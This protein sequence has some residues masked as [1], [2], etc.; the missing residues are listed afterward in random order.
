MTSDELFDA[1]ILVVD[2]HPEN[3]MLLE[4]ML[5]DEGYHQITCVTDARQVLAMLTPA[6]DIILLDVRMPYLSGLDVLMLIRQTLGN[7]APPVVILTADNDNDTKNK[8]L[9]LGAID[10]LTK[11][12]DQQEVIQRIY[13]LL[14]VHLRSQQHREQA[15][16]LQELVDSQTAELRK[17]SLTDTLT[18]LPNR[19]ALLEESRLRLARN[20]PLAVLML[21]I[22]GLSNI[23][24]IQGYLATEALL[25]YLSEM[26]RQCAATRECF[27]GIWE[28]HQLVILSPDLDEEA[29]K[30]RAE[31]L[32]RLT[33]GEHTTDERL[34]NID[35]R[36]GCCRASEHGEQVEQLFRQAMQAI[37]KGNDWIG[38]Y[39]P[40]IDIAEK[41]RH[42]IRNMLNPALNNQEFYLVFQPKYQLSNNQLTGAEALLRW[43]S[44]ELGAI[45]P[46]EF[47]PIAENTVSMLKLGDQVIMLALQSL[48]R[49]RQQYPLP[50][51]FQ[52]AVNLSVV[53]LQPGI[54]DK[55]IDWCAEYQVA[56][57]YL[58]FEIT[59]SVLMN[60]MQA[61]LHELTLLQR[62]GFE[63]AIDDFGTGYSSL[64]Y[65]RT[66][67][68]QWLKLDRS[69]IC[70]LTDSITDQHL[71]SSIIQMAHGLGFKVVAEGVEQQ[72]EADLL[73]QFGCD[74]GQGYLFARPL[75]EA[76]FL[77]L[78]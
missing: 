55:I 32:L 72:T 9:E 59:E 50:A 40:Q 67:P 23:S 5:E 77:T 10:F 46:F 63:I 19:R 13:N 14:S 70:Q 15:I 30:K 60:N 76:D 27:V 51:H 16:R 7:L 22:D 68:V 71:V 26:I 61:A 29:L 38:Y 37:P 47:I 25:K 36:I 12:F 2:D 18:G 28:T 73:K 74:Q 31:R 45:G 66:L 49:W 17:L 20:E 6:P 54:A 53:Q 11:P 78:L 75:P 57:H 21:T 3:V 44:H 35:C 4:S 39:S 42:K 56:H 8:A 1:R 62:A 41:R 48:A 64:S 58:Q 24:K 52:L 43:E 33:V 65:L 34:F 69:F